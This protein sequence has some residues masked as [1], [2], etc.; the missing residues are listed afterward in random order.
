[1]K[2]QLGLQYDITHI[3][4]PHNYPDQPADHPFF[5]NNHPSNSEYNTYYP[6]QFLT[7][8]THILTILMTIQTTLTTILSILRVPLAALAITKIV[9]LI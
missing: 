9:S 7:I 3:S 1:M 8:L 4:N 6:I 2:H 5:T